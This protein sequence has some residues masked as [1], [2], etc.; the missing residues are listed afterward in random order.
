MRGSIRRRGRTY[1]WYLFVLDPATGKPRQR[2]KGGYRTNLNANN[3]GWF[4]W[5]RV[6][7]DVVRVGRWSPAGAADG[8]RLG[9]SDDHDCLARR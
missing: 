5:L 3:L 1:T 4:G 7:C 6:V 9:G 8:C 2:S